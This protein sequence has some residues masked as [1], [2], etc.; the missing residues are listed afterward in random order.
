MKQSQ[1]YVRLDHVQELL[2]LIKHRDSF[3]DWTDN[4]DKFNKKVFNTVAFIERNAKEF[5]PATDSKQLHTDTEDLKAVHRHLQLE[6]QYVQRDYQANVTLP[7]KE[8]EVRALNLVAQQEAFIQYLLYGKPTK[9]Q[10]NEE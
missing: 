5:T 1:K 10:A 2:K 9:E 8:Y 4:Y 7:Y 6:V 3:M